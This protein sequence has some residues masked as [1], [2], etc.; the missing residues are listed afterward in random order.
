VREDVLWVGR[1][2]RTNQEGIDQL[3]EILKK[4]KKIK[5]VSFDLPY[6][7]GLF[8][9]II[10]RYFIWWH[11]DQILWIYIGPKSCLHLQSLISFPSPHL[12]VIYPPLC[13]N[14]M[15]DEMNKMV[16]ETNHEL[17]MKD[18]EMVEVIEVD[19]ME[20][21]AMG[22]NIL[23]L[24]W[25]FWINEKRDWW[26]IFHLIH[27]RIYHLPFHWLISSYHLTISSSPINIK[28]GLRDGCIMLDD[29]KLDRIA[30]EIERRHVIVKRFCC[31]REISL[32][33]ISQSTISSSHNLSHN[34]QSHNL[35]SYDQISVSQSTI[36]SDHV[37]VD[38]TDLI[39]VIRQ[40][41]GRLV[42]QKW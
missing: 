10:I 7:E 22:T 19:E 3:N 2:F 37:I 28:I 24:G 38:L 34:L 18:D 12:I 41:G 26:L 6:H 33:F 23:G 14:E 11:I 15:V 36:S 42:S 32:S 27:S 9:M 25:L 35:P 21:R 5:V 17:M 1:G 16:N 4:K 39:Y 30:H 13:S 31:V 40:R 8:F 29:K 20:F